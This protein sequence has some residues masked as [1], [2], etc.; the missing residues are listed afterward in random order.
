MG[1]LLKGRVAVVTGSGQGIGR[2]IALAFAEQGARVVT[3]NRKPGSTG[4]SMVTEKQ[5]DAL[6]ADQRDWFKQ[7]LEEEHGDA[8]TTARDIR[9]LGGEA[10]PFFGDISKIDVAEQLIKTV[11][12][13][14]GRIDILCNVA[15]AFGFSDIEDIS[16][17]LWDRVTSV[18]PKGYFNTMKFA[19]PYM[20]KQKFGRIL[21]C[22]SPAFMG[23]VL[24]Q[25]E[26]SAANGGVIGLTRAAAIELNAFG[27]TVN[28]FAPG[29]RTRASYELEAARILKSI[30]VEGKEF[31]DIDDT[32]PPN[33]IA[34]FLVYLA[35]DAAAGVSGS[36]FM[37]GGN[38]VGRFAE[39]FVEKR[40]FK[41]GAEPWTPEV[42]SEAAEKELFEGYKSLCE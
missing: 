14:Y 31:V 35:S 1:E 18:K 25:A 40:L 33:Y 4:S 26:Y 41:E 28:S 27:I 32:P 5:V 17:E 10:T 16:E 21:N 19:V 20:K 38:F 9:A 13:T 22:S 6:A 29:A 12:D 37:L 23:G 7:G 42:I 11:I 24:K 39:P 36:V 15:G 34:P 3:N 30:V 8:E 2:A